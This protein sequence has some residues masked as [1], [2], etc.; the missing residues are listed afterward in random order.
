MRKYIAVY[1]LFTLLSFRVFAQETKVPVK[2]L[3]ENIK[4]A[5]V[6]DRR[7]LMNQ[8]KLRLREMNKESRKKTMMELKQSLNGKKDNK[9]KHKQKRHKREHRRQPTY[10]RI[11]QHQGGGHNR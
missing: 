2:T 7:N 11:G 6:E 3:I 4:K 8:L 5:K 9:A 10:R 1:L